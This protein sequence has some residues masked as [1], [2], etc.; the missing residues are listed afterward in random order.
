MNQ[1]FN[2]FEEMA[3]AEIVELF[4]DEKFKFLNRSEAERYEGAELHASHILVYAN[5]GDRLIF[6]EDKVSALAL[7][8]FELTNSSTKYSTSSKY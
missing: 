3:V 8:S 6:E 2:Q 1:F 4:S 7:V 5:T